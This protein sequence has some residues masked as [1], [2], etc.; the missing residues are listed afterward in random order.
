MGEIRVD[1]HHPKRGKKNTLCLPLGLGYYLSDTNT[2]NPATL[3][4]YRVRVRL[5]KLTMSKRCTSLNFCNNNLCFKRDKQENFRRTK[6]CPRDFSPLHGKASFNFFLLGNEVVCAS[7]SCWKNMR[8]VGLRSLLSWVEVSQVLEPRVKR[9]VTERC[10]VIF[11][12]PLIP[13]PTKK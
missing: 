10:A 1:E 6:M 5:P 4:I 13:T 12:A 9:I 7:Q 8:H 11:S 2:N 3:R